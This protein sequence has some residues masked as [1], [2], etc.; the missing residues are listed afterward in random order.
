MASSW[1]TCEGGEREA[2]GGECGE[3]VCIVGGKSA[4]MM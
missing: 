1:A 4:S 2:E 3:H